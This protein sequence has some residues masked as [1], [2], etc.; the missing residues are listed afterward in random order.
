MLYGNREALMR[1]IACLVLA[2]ATAAAQEAKDENVK[3]DA[4]RGTT[5]QKPKSAD[6]KFE[7]EGRVT[8]AAICASHKD[9]LSV[10]VFA[11]VQDGGSSWWSL[12]DYGQQTVQDHKSSL[13]WKS[14]ALTGEVANGRFAGA[15][16]GN[17]TAYVIEAIVTEKDDKQYDLREWLWKKGDMLYR[18]SVVTPVGEYAKREKELTVV[19]AGIK[20]FKPKPLKDK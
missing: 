4:E 19:Y 2:T 3:T 13:Q 6:W 1:L 5:F 8:A 17:P 9:G 14:F 12:R 10:E 20:V 18:V 7:K 16:V 15:G 11:S